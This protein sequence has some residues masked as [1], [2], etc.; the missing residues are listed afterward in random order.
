MKPFIYALVDPQN[1]TVI[2]YIGMTCRD[3]QRPFRHANAARRGDKRNTPLM[4]WIR[5]LQAEGRSYKVLYLE[6]FDAETSREIIYEAEQDYIEIS[7][8]DGHLLMNL[9]DRGP[10]TQG[11][12]WSDA[13]RHKA[14][15]AAKARFK[16]PEKQAR[17][18]AGQ[19]KRYEN[20]E[21]RAKLQINVHG[22]YMSPEAKEKLRLRM[23]ENTYTRGRKLS[24][25]H[26]ERIRQAMIGNKHTLG[27]KLSPEHIEKI[28]Q[29]HT[30]RKCSEEIKTRMSQIRKEAWAAGKY[31]RAENG[32]I[33]QNQAK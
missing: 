27:R 13:S 28:K 14:S 32:Q 24:E 4:A 7:R 10:G 17:H 15:T 11:L 6:E 9:V 8:I 19:K 12:K 5:K 29:L 3:P 30:G 20:S 18:S 26:K 25:D 33:L 16:D 23:K 1:S 22:G 31:Q 2:R 21:E